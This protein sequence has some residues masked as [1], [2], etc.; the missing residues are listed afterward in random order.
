[1]RFGKHSN[2]GSITDPPGSGEKVKR[3]CPECGEEFDPN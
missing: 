3:V 1:M 2:A